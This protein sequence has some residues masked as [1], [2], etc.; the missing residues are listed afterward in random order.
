MS[1]RRAEHVLE[2]VTRELRSSPSP[3]L[4]WAAIESRLPKTPAPNGKPHF[5]TTRLLLT[6]AAFAAV[7]AAL[8]FR[9]AP[10]ERPATVVSHQPVAAKAGPVNGDALPPGAV[11]SAATEPKSVEHP[12]R[13]TWTL[14]PGSR[15]SIVEKGR[16]LV[17]RLEHGSLLARVV[18][19]TAPETF[20]VEAADVRVA[21]HGTVFEVS[22]ADGSVGVDVTEGRVLVGP[23]VQPGVGK[24]LE[25]PSV[26][27]FSLGGE[28]LEKP[29]PKPRE[30]APKPNVTPE[31]T[32]PALPE[33]SGPEQPT[34]EEVERIVNEVVA[35]TSSCFRQRTVA[36]DG[37]KV[38]AHTSLTL[39]TTREGSVSEVAFDPPLAP[40]VQECVNAG[41]PALHAAPTRSGFGATRSVDFER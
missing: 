31:L 39:R 24:L 19:S 35:L 41:T 20:V 28:P 26:Q 22:L 3:E 38:T 27:R 8:T 33:S 32:P 18:P 13:A 29:L 7:A 14:T 15:A 9:F 17:V 4:D 1:R 2:E 11:V 12:T 6:A 10:A 23:R 36:S 40:S 5:P 34:T 37:V 30:R 21:V 25:S 16:L